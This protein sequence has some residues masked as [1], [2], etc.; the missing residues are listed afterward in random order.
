[1]KIRTAVIGVGYLG[2]YH[3][4]KYAKLPTSELVAVVDNDLPTAKTIAAQYQTQALSAYQDL[5][6]LVDGVS[7]AVPTQHHYAIAKFFLEHGVHVLVEKPITTT[8]SQ[9][10]ELIY[11]AKIHQCILQVG[12]LQ[13]F[14]PTLIAMQPHL[15]QPHFI[16]SERLAPFRQRGTEVNVILDL[17]IHDLVLILSLVKS[18]IEHIEALGTVV[19]SNDIDL[20]HAQLKFKNGCVAN[21]TASRINPSFKRELRIFQQNS[22]FTLDLHQTHLTITHK[23]NPENETI[24]FEKTDELLTEINAFLTAILNNTAP[25]VS[26]EDGKNALAAALY[27]SKLIQSTH[28]T[29]VNV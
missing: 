21:L 2:R 1:M 8:L 20:A 28:M 24:H 23:N 26:G 12:H 4:E 9:A 29:K 3:A 18:P 5:I 7:I 27:I 22:Y 10:E 19:L 17:M 25:I 6:N 14:N 16:E 15:N 13:R 11:L